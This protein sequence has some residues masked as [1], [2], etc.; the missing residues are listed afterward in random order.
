MLVMF[1]GAT[2]GVAC[3]LVFP[4][5]GYGPGTPE[6]DAA[7]A[8]PAVDAADAFVP[9]CA[10]T[11]FPPP[12]AA[13][14]PGGEDVAI[15]LAVSNLVLGVGTAQTP[16]LDLDGLCSCPDEP[17]CVSPQKTCDREGGVD[18][19]FDD[20]LAKFGS[21]SAP[22]KQD[23]LRSSIDDGDTTFLLVIRRYNGM[24]NDT[25]VELGVIASLGTR[26]DDAT[27][28]PTLPKRDGTDEWTVDPGS[29]SNRSA[30]FVPKTVATQGYVSG[31][32]LVARGDF[33]ISLGSGAPLSVSL[34][35]GVII[36]RIVRDGIWRMTEGRLAGRWSTSKLLTSLAVLPDPIDKSSYV[37][38]DSGTYQA[39]KPQLCAAADISARA[40]TDLTGQK[41][42]ALSIGAGFEAVQARIGAL[43]PP[44]TQDAGCGP[45]WKDDCAP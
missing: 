28:K 21:F 42:R 25:N 22:I 19:A 38:G 40:A 30:P 23:R 33:V 6:A 3:S 10:L 16:G 41:C 37:C 32:I 12:P 36:G 2:A 5:D 34:D 7:D 8:A 24:P 18:N 26:T 45:D 17:P 27:G 4:Y 9:G 11:R 1:A 44:R 20:L 35:D 31:G 13:D 14:D 15:D 29:V 43:A 39:Y